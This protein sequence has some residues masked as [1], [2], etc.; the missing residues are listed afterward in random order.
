M[1]HLALPRIRS[2][3]SNNRRGGA[4]QG[5]L[6]ALAVLIVLLIGGSVFVYMN[7]KGW[8]AGSIR[9]MS[10]QVVS[11]S[12]LVQAD[13]D[14]INQKISTVMQD[15]QD[16][17]VSFEQLG[18]VAKD[19]AEGPL[20]PLASVSVIQKEYFPVAAYT[21]E[22]ADAA[23]RS[24]ERC[25]RGIAEK[26][27]S[28][29]R[30]NDILAPVSTTQPNGQFELKPKEKVTKDEV[31]KMVDTAKA[32]ADTAKVPDEPYEVDIA[33]VVCDSIDRALGKPTP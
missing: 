20:L 8:M 10:E 21:P 28:H 19:L 6:I 12:S 3:N 4:A 32:E 22:E 15:F 13:K 25:A 16:G 24:L 23:K 7:W 30:I 14:K 18:T 31:R 26:T 11:Q 29:T 1:G 27:I 33:G 9:T 17:K 5:C 2:L